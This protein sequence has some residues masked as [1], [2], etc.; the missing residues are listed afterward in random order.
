MLKLVERHPLKLLKKAVCEGQIL[1]VQ[2]LPEQLK[3]APT[4]QASG[5]TFNP[6]ST[7]VV[8]TLEEPLFDG[9]D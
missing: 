5:A 3:A 6:T 9:D 8:N 7:R 2:G 1:R 4:F